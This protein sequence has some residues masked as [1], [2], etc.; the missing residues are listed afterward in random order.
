MEP[1][2]LQF[3]DFDIEEE[4]ARSSGG[5]VFRARWRTKRAW[6]FSVAELVIPWCWC[7]SSHRWVIF[8]D[9]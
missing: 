6:L 2:A 3:G 8:I 4:L 7:S 9:D 5:S 1:S